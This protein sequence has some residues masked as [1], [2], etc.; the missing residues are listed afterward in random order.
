MNRATCRYSPSVARFP[1][2]REIAVAVAAMTVSA[3]SMFVELLLLDKATPGALAVVAIV[4]ACLPLLLLRRAPVIALAL[5]VVTLLGV[6]TAAGIY[7]M[8]MVPVVMCTYEAARQHGRATALWIGIVNVPVVMI[9]LQVTSPHAL[10]GWATA[11]YVGFSVLPLAFGVAAHDRGAYTAALVDRAET[12]ERTRE[13]EALRRVGE[14]RLR[15]ARDV[16]D[17]VAHTMVAINVQAG[18]GAHLIDRDL[19]GARTRL[20][21]IKRVSGDA[22]TELRSMLEIM[23][24]DDGDDDL[25]SPTLGLEAVGDLRERLGAAGI[26]LDVRVDPTAPP[27]PA[28]VGAT[29]YR[30]VQEALTNVMRHVGPTSARVQVIRRDEVVLI[31]IEDDG[32]HGDDRPALAGTGSG[33]G[34]RG[35]RE[36]AAAIGGALEAGPRPQGGWRVTASLPVGAA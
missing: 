34:L 10:F 22:L 4:V 28:I 20:L 8:I 14:E 3:I 1:V 11:T 7:N 19:A 2:S 12:A 16:H 9:I 30:I 6:L 33:N 31:E 25:E 35:M 26:T 21:D 29:G 13:Q 15:I 23:R 17:V 36:R 27:L 5:V 18:V 32:A 24:E